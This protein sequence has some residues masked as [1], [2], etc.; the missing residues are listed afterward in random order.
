VR[1]NE[2]LARG[3]DHL[4]QRA[5]HLLRSQTLSLLL[6]LSL[7]LRLCSFGEVSA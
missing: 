1:S 7:L 3:I 4:F 6:C 5:L 2:S